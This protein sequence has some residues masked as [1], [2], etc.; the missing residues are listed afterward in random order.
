ML[1]PITTRRRCS[2]GKRGHAVAVGVLIMTML[3]ACGPAWDQRA[4]D[5]RLTRRLAAGDAILDAVPLP[6]E[7]IRNGR[8]A[9][10]DRDSATLDWKRDF[11][12]KST[13]AAALRTIGDALTGGGWK[14]NGSCMG[15]HGAK[16][17]FYEKDGYEIFPN[18]TDVPCPDGT[19]GCVLINI[20]MSHL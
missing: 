8:S 7:W 20:W 11:R 2:M 16:C 5:E 1:M 14:P 6:A 10:L 18:A 3:S 19:S 9:E 12:A 13:E 17:Y 4:F 15:P